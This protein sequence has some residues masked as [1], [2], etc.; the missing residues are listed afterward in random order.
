MGERF[1]QGFCWR[2]T[3]KGGFLHEQRS[4]SLGRCCSQIPL[5]LSYRCIVR[6]WYRC[7]CFKTLGAHAY[8]LS[9]SLTRPLGLL[10]WPTRYLRIELQ[11]LGVIPRQWGRRWCLC[12]HLSEVPLQLL[13]LLYLHGVILSLLRHSVRRLLVCVVKW[14]WLVLSLWHSKT[15]P[16]IRCA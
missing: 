5:R 16:W 7:V 2:F 8:V 3:V 9:S 15:H 4:I 1:A 6:T 11:W 13:L 14:H 10:P 12:T